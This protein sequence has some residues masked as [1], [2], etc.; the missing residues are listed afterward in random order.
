MVDIE[1]PRKNSC[2][3]NQGRHLDQNRQI[4]EVED[5]ESMSKSSVV[6]N[7]ESYLHKIQKSR[8]LTAEQKAYYCNLA[9]SRIAIK[10]KEEYSPHL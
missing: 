7:T 4:A 10:D 1:N 8:V 6:S 9:T 5:L 2:G 3:L